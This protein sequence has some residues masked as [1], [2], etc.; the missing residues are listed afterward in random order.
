VT[1][2]EA[3]RP[4]DHRVATASVYDNIFMSDESVTFALTTGAAASYELRNY[5]GTVVA[6][7]ALSG[8]TL[9]LGVLPL[10]WYKLYLIRSTAIA[11]PW[12]SAGGETYFVVCRAG[13]GLPSRPTDG[14]SPGADPVG[15][16][17]DYPASG[18]TRL[19]PY[20]HSL[21]NDANHASDLTKCL[22]DVAVEASTWGT[23][24]TARPL[25]SIANY[26]NGQGALSSATVTSAVSQ[27]V[28]AGCTTV[29][30]QNEPM[31]TIPLANVDTFVTQFATFS[32]AVRAGGGLAAGPSTITV[33]GPMFTDGGGG[34]EWARRFFVGGG[35]A[36]TDV[37]SFHNYNGILGSLRTGRTTLDGFVEMLTITGNQSKPR[38]NTETFSYFAHVYGSTEVRLQTEWTMLEM[39]LLEQY[40][41]P[42]ERAS[43][44]YPRSHGFWDYPSWWMNSEGDQTPNP[45]VAVVRVW[46]QELAGRSY[47]ARLNFGSEDDQFV[48]SRF[49][50]SSGAS[51]V[52]FQSDG[53][54]GNLTFTVTGASTIDSVDAWGNVTT[55]TVTGGTVTVP[56]NQLP[57]YI[58]CPSGVTAT[59]VAVDYG[60]DAVAPQ[61]QVIGVSAPASDAGFPATAAIDND[62]S[63]Y[64]ATSTTLPADFVVTFPNATRFDRVVVRCGPPWQNESAL[65]DFDIDAKV[66]GSWTTLATYTEPATVVTWASHADVGRGFTDSYYSRKS[67][68]VL[69]LAN[70]VEATDVRV[71][72]RDATYGGGATLATTNGGGVAGGATG[73]TGPRRLC[74]SEV[75]VYLSGK[76]DGGTAVAGQPMLIVT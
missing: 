73:Q 53:R 13:L 72:A 36:A 61:R 74:L 71:H 54:E 2:N 42:K 27:L 18:F 75:R 32:A 25:V 37:I 52:T 35:S 68:W 45:L 21:R 19:G 55:R 15:E 29:E 63:T 58:R 70:A 46:S 8:T 14:T 23:A 17:V 30:G 1:W 67:T 56:A 60:V 40:G 5:Y 4:S 10:G 62:A 24:D 50:A 69:D 65:L 64:R 7:G 57:G 43:T 39:Q 11:A 3:T 33:A 76:T 41:V 59:P 16:G 47:S 28:A 51:T 66:G 26:P 38:L 49:T 48:G 20:R 34:R 9:N 12:G 31:V 44:F 22:S 6:S